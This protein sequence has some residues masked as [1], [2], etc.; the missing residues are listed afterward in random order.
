MNGRKQQWSQFIQVSVLHK[1]SQKIELC[2]QLEMVDISLHFGLNCIKTYVNCVSA[3]LLFKYELH[4]E[5]Y[6]VTLTAG[7]QTT[8]LHLPSATQII[9]LQL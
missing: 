9:S 7:A 2:L 8:E 3:Q 1:L 5:Y 6:P 4:I